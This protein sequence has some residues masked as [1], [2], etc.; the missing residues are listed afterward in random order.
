MLYTINELY[1]LLHERVNAVYGIFK[2]FFGEENVD[3]QGLSPEVSFKNRI[4]HALPSWQIEDIQYEVDDYDS[5]QYEL[6]DGIISILKSNFEDEKVSIFVHWSTVTITNE[7][8]K[9]ID[10]QDLY[11]QVQFQ[12]NGRIPYENHG[13][14]LN[15]ST[16]TYEQFASG[17]LHSHIQNLSKEDL[18]TFKR[19]CLGSGPIKDTISTLKNDYDETMW[20]L[21][22]Q[23]LSM[24]VTVESL[25]GVPYK[26][27]E[28]IKGE[29]ELYQYRGY[30]LKDAYESSFTMVFTREELKNFIEYYLK[31]GH[32]SISFNNGRFTYGIPYYE[33]IID[34]SNAFIDFYNEHLASD[35]DKLSKCFD[36]NL[37]MNARFDG[38]KFYGDNTSGD[39]HR[40][41]VYKGK[42]ILT[43]K[44]KEVKLRIIDPS[45]ETQAS[46]TTIINHNLAMY[47]LRNILRTIN[48]RYRN[49]Y[50]RSKNSLDPEDK[51]PSSACQRVIYI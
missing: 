39:I 30:N 27:L 15:R 22:C 42:K 21:F 2:D 6:S 24:Y 34:L 46:R 36:Y 8:N 50:K 32:L 20:M 9:S 47:I 12:L 31:N 38:T 1:E 48:Y 40:F 43:F 23:E 45:E 35:S 44:G 4:K 25:E 11:A 3:L 14:L 13:F 18:R 33:Y 5:K 16:Y 10:I 28:K 29:K 7:N 19:P 17:Y 51:E 41:D 49:E 26:Y 37:I